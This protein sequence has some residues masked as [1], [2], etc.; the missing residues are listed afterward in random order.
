VNTVHWND[1]GDKLVSGSDDTRVCIW[2]AS[3][4]FFWAKICACSL[5]F[6]CSFH[7][8]YRL[9]EKDY[10]EIGKVNG[11]CLLAIESGH[12]ASTPFLPP[13]S[14]TAMCFSGLLLFGSLAFLT[15]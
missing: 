15:C 14:I 8:S 9:I 6:C 2:D 13:V 7:L 3:I 5:S 10:G 12:T 4:I 11:K 1:P